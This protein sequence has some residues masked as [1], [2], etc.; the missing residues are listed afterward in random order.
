LAAKNQSDVCLESLAKEFKK[1]IPD[2]GGDG[3]NGEIGSG[4]NISDSPGYAALLPH[5]GA[6]KFSHQKIGIKQ[7]NDKPYFDHRSPGILVHRE[8]VNLRRTRLLPSD[9]S[10]GVAA[11]LDEL[12]LGLR[13]ER[14]KEET[15]PPEKMLGS[16]E[17]VDGDPY[18]FLIPR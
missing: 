5:A 3:G 15:I 1:A 8:S 14:R 9:S 7:E 18:A 17:I 6:L 12:L 10:R 4:K 16:I 13:A 11:I 2:E